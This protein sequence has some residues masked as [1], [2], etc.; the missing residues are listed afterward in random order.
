MVAKAVIDMFVSWFMFYTKHYLKTIF[1]EYIYFYEFLEK[2]VF[3]IGNIIF[4]RFRVKNFDS[5]RKFG[6]QKIRKED[7]RM[8]ATSAVIKVNTMM[9][10][11]FRIRVGTLL[12]YSVSVIR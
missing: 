5:I 8:S 7:A 9:S 12:I 4:V 3:N 6:Y 2:L 10:T 11:F 1:E